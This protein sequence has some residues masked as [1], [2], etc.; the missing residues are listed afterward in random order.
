VGA[1]VGSGDGA[2]LEPPLQAE[3]SSDVDATHAAP[4]SDL[5]WEW[6][7]YEAPSFRVGKSIG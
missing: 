3:T 5:P 7:F 1:A 6:S 2:E 4:K